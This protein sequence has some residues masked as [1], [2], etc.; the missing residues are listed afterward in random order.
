M[1]EMPGPVPRPPEHFLTCC[2][3]SKWRTNRWLSS[4][5]C[6]GLMTM[7]SATSRRRIIGCVL[8]L[9]R[10]ILF[11]RVVGLHLDHPTIPDL[12]RR[13]PSPVAMQKAGTPRL[14][15]RLTK[16]APQMGRRLAL[17]ITAALNVQTVV[18]V[19]TNAATLPPRV[20]RDSSP[21]LR[22]QRAE[23]AIMVE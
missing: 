22:S 21:P 15:A 7:S 6:A 12:L 14:T 4:R 16:L 18:V 5:C 17:E 8:F 2:V 19:G 23:I 13:Y 20:S 10:P 9:R 3:P 1:R 11:Q